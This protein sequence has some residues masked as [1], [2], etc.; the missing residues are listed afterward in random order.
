MCIW[1]TKGHVHTAEDAPVKSTLYFSRS[2]RKAH[3]VLRNSRWMTSGYHVLEVVASCH[4]VMLG[5]VLSVMTHALAGHT[6]PTQCSC[7]SLPK[8][9]KHV[10]VHVFLCRTRAAK[11][12]KGFLLRLGNASTIWSTVRYSALLHAERSAL[13]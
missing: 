12:F 2:C 10:L 9:S 5:S 4:R 8:E 3:W 11:I 13:S 7:V 6:W 1:D